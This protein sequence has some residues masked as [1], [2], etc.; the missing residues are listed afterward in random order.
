MT[1]SLPKLPVILFFGGS[2]DEIAGFGG[3]VF[4]CFI[5]SKFHQQELIKDFLNMVHP[6]SHIPVEKYLG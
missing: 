5:A 6:F 4:L 2:Q 3:M 1:L